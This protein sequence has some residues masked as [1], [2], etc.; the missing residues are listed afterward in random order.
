[1]FVKDGRV[2]LPHG[3][4]VFGQTMGNAGNQMQLRFSRIVFPNGKDHAFSGIAAVAGS[5]KGKHA[6]RA[7]SILSGAAI[8]STGVFVPGGSGY[9]DVFAR[10]ASQAAAG[11]VGRDISYYRNTDAAPVV[12]VP[13]NKK[14]TIMV[15]RPL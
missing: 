3:S 9:G 15:D 2:I 1:D 14:I 10:N 7:L 13:S 6:G 5:L 8:G 12:S 11:D 4:R